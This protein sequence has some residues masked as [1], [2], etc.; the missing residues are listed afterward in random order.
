MRIIAGELRGRSFL[1]PADDQTTRPIIDRVK[2]SLMDRLESFGLVE[3]GAV[4]DL[5]SGTGSLGLESLSR[6]SDHCVFVDGDRDAVKRLGQN[7]DKLELNEFSSVVQG[8]VFAMMWL[9]R[10]PHDMP[11]NVVFLDPPYAMA[12]EEIW[13]E[14]FEKLAAAVIE[15]LSIDGALVLRVPKEVDPEPITGWRGPRIERY[16]SMKIAFYQPEIPESAKMQLLIATGNPHKLDEIRT[17]MDSPRLELLSLK[18][19]DLDVPEPVEDQTTFEGNAE[20]KAKYYAKHAGMLCL[21]DDSGLEVDAL[22][23]EPGV[24]SAR[25]SGVE[26]DRNTVDPANNK[27]LMAE[28]A[29]VPLEERAARFVCAMAL[30]DADGNIQHTLRG[31]LEGRILMSDE[32][33]DPDHPER[34]RGIHG[35]GY[36]PLF[37]VDGL[38]NTSAELEPEHKNAISHRG[39]ASR[40]MW[41]YL[42]DLMDNQ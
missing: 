40:L 6:G 41:D 39:N 37:L 13:P 20:L 14:R 7:L 22:N 18:D 28:L 34:G 36:D 29:D 12:E 4:A 9:H 30:A 15:R 8:D 35:F 24:Y 2:Q 26:G 11:L 31:T 19:I 5:F 3:D 16:G 32:V 10:I 23:G 38:R 1:G 17:I 27:K 33:S 21:A 42:I 25:Y